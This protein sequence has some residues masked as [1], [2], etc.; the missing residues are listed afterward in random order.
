VQKEKKD[1]YEI[2]KSD[3][4]K[5]SDKMKQIQED[6]EQMYEF[7]QKSN[8]EIVRLHNEILVSTEVQALCFS[9]I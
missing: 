2:L 9:L 7:F 8:F 3:H 1:D 6:L 4:V 5:Q